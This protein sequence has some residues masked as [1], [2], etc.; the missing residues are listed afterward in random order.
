[1]LVVCFRMSHYRLVTG[2][3]RR[4]DEWV[5]YSLFPLLVALADGLGW[6]APGS[7]VCVRWVGA[8]G[9]CTGGQECMKK[10]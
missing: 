8:L 5:G 4:M 2:Q 7:G 6:R 10:K 3:N 9:R 1:M